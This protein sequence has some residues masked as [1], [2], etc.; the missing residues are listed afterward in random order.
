MSK[1]N[2]EFFKEKKD[3][4][5]VKDKLLGCYLAP[6]FQKVLATG[7]GALII[8]NSI[9]RKLKKLFPFVKVEV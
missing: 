2:N 3:W 5:L 9:M 1:N 6:Y 4:S 8:R 7:K